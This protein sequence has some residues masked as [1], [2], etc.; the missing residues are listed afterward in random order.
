MTGFTITL[1][2]GGGA[3]VSSLIKNYA[4]SGKLVFSDPLALITGAIGGAGGGAMGCGLHFMGALSGSSCLP[5]ALSR[6]EA[7]AL[8]MSGIVMPPPAPPP[9]PPPPPVLNRVQLLTALDPNFPPAFP[10]IGMGTYY[11]EFNDAGAVPQRGQSI[12]FVTSAE[13]T[14][15]DGPASPR[16]YIN[17]RQKLFWLEAT[18]AGG[19]PPAAQ[20]ADLVI[21]VHGIGRHVFPC[22]S[23]RA[24]AA[25][26]A[27][28]VNFTRPMYKDDFAAFLA[29]DPHI[30]AFLLGITV[31]GAG[32]A[33]RTPII[34]LA[35][36]FSALPLGCCSLSQELATRLGA[37][38]YGGRP[39]VYPW[40]DATG[41]PQVPDWGGW[42]R[43]DP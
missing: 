32:V 30:A 2:G 35:V 14:G 38:V 18:A 9:P 24:A 41:R 17:Q 42:I 23:H 20:R 15:M 13:F 36:C 34:K 29:G 1:G 5:V 4:K 21:G 7:D 25:A 16:R 39:P 40:L 19:A 33:G 11:T 26:G 27:G 6:T 37:I 43:Y 22:I 10:N 28:T 31:G 12:A 3:I 8:R